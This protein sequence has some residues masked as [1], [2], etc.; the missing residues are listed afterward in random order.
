MVMGEWVA[1]RRIGRA[2]RDIGMPI[3]GSF[4]EFMGGFLRAVLNLILLRFVASLLFTYS[5]VPAG[6]A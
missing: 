3:E 4:Y 5:V 2:L 6:L 1:G